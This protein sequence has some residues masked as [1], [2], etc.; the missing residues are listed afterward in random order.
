MRKVVKSS[1]REMGGES[2]RWRRENWRVKERR[3]WRLGFRR[4]LMVL[5]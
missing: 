2:W 4:L 3:V 1:E 5:L